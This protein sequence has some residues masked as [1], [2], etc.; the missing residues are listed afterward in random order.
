MTRTTTTSTNAKSLQFISPTLVTHLQ[1]R[2]RQTALPPST[3]P[4]DRRIL[5]TAKANPGS[6]LAT[7]IPPMRLPRP[8]VRLTSRQMLLDQRNTPAPFAALWPTLYR[9]M[10]DIVGAQL[11]A[12]LC[13]MKSPPSSALYVRWAHPP[14]VRRASKFTCCPPTERPAQRRLF[15]S[16]TTLATHLQP[17]RLRPP[18]AR[19]NLNPAPAQQTRSVAPCVF[20]DLTSSLVQ[21]STG[22][23]TQAWIALKPLE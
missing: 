15:P 17:Q 19:D 20:E 11:Q 7:T 22:Q 13:I 10:I 9:V 3:A 14:Q 16:P 23:N 12:H 1:M 8:C 18:R 2:P 5:I 6:L 21:R 4:A